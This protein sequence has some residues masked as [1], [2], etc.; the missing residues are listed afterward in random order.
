MRLRLVVTLLG[1]ASVIRAQVPGPSAADSALIHRILSAEDRRDS[2]EGALAL[3][4]RH[5]DPR[6]RVIAQRAR[7]RIRDPRFVSRDS[8]PPLPPP[9]AWPE[10]T[11]K[12]R[13]RALAT[14]RNNC[15]VLRTALTDSVWPVRLRAADLVTRECANDDLLT[16]VLRA[17]VD[18]LPPSASARR[19]GEVSWHA[20]AH[21]IVALA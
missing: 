6:V 16:A 14:Q 2:T 19:R 17:W 11:W 7:A 8:L 5:A 18:G 3:A 12:Q 21:A 4:L 20:G 13:Y 10:P 15:G 1:V 9:N